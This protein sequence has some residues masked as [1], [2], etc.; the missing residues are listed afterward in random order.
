MFLT[1]Q[2]LRSGYRVLSR[3]GRVVWFHCEA[4]MIRR[5]DGSPWFIHGVAFDI[6]DLKLAEA[7]LGDERDVLSAILN[8]VGALIAVLDPEGRI[9][10]FNRAWPSRPSG[11]RL[12]KCA[13]ASCASCS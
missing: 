12:P 13:A 2:P 10:Q 6:T 7:A 5:S 3:D 1:G 4:K 9:V 11:T 8:T